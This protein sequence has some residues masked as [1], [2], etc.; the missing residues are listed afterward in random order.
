MYCEIAREMW[1]ELQNVFSQ[2]NGPKIY[3]LQ[4]EISQI[5]QNQMSVTEFYT[6]FKRLWDQLLN[7]EPMPECSCGAMKTLN[8]SHSKAYVMRFL[9]GLN[10]SFDTVRSQILMM[11]PFPSMSKV[12]SLISQEESHKSAGHGVSGSSQSDTMAMYVNSKGSFKGNGRKERRT[13]CNMAGHTIEKCYKLHGY[14]PGYKPK[15]KPI[16]NANQASFNFGDG[17]LVVGNQCPISK[18][19]CEKLLAFLNSGTTGTGTALGDT[20]HAANTSISCMA[21]S[22]GGVSGENSGS[23]GSS[24]QSQ[25]NPYPVFNPTLM[26]GNHSNYFLH[27]SFQHSI[28]FARK[29]DR[30]AF[31]GSDWVMDTGATDH[32]VHSVSRFTS[33]I[34][35]LN[36]FVNLPNGESALVTHIGTVKISTKLVL[37]NVLRVPSFTFNLLSV[38]KLAKSIS[39]CLMFFGTLCFIQDMA[40]WSTIGLGKEYNGLYLLEQNSSASSS[41]STDF[42]SINNV[43]AVNNV[44]V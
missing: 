36:T 32:M 27:P 3:N 28:F 21:T 11:D 33:I 23:I 44:H 13:H 8:N 25:V 16:A 24:S 12:Y 30:T 29:V 5:R 42:N 6:K 31:N 37:Y 19:Q 26:S 15:G 41:C 7:Y 17:A 34:A 20:H 14:P 10:D 2:G 4:T 38:S 40:H 18:A 22:A 39:C 43:H 9:M 35:V 1:I